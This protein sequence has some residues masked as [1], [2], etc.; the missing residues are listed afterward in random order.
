MI[1]P[2][3]SMGI[4]LLGAIIVALFQVKYIVRD[5]RRELVT[6]QQQMAKEQ[7]SIHVL[8]AE[9]GY[10]NQPERLQAL[11]DKYLHLQTIH[12]PQVVASIGDLPQ[13]NEATQV[14]IDLQD[15]Q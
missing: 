11:N 3:V 4:I 10:L 8:R 13:Q 7:Q 5:L 12:S 1:R 2:L 15:D 14:A 6:V 9:W